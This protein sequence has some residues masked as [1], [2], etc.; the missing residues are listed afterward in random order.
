MTYS[1][2]RFFQTKVD[3]ET[4]AVTVDWVV[5]TATIVMLGVAAAWYV[6]SS[7]PVVANALSSYMTGVT[8]LPD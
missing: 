8:V 7:V 6:T 1:V 2:L 3:D 4:G 5:L